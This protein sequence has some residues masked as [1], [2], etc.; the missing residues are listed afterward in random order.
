[1]SGHFAF[2]I[3]A[4]DDEWAYLQLCEDSDN[5][6]SSC[7]Q[8]QQR[9]SCQSL[10]VYRWLFP[11]GASQILTVAQSLQKPFVQGE[12]VSLTLSATFFR[13]MLL[14]LWGLPLLGFLLMISL[15]VFWSEVL[16]F[17]LGLVVAMLL[18]RWGRR[19]TLMRLT[20]LFQ[21]SRQ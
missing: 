18:Y 1:M 20:Q 15:S 2:R 17:L 4:V 19:Y 13:N 7:Q 9:G 10:S 6:T 3:V 16:S 12:Q 8:C 21:R 5:H 11:Q 14:I